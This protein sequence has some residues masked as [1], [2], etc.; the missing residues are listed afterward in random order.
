[1]NTTKATPTPGEIIYISQVSH[2]VQSST[3]WQQNAYEQAG[4]E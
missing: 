2:P 3:S 4:T 1:M